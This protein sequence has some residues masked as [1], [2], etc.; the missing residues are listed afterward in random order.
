MS[1][2]DA[3]GVAI[4]SLQ[5]SCHWRNSH[6]WDLSMESKQLDNLV[7]TGSLK[8]EP[9]IQAEYDGLVVSG[10]KS[11]PTPATNSWLSKVGSIWHTT[12]R[13]LLHLRRFA[14]MVLRPRT[15]MGFPGDPTHPEPWA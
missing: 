12:E 5:G 15:S 3:F 7:R 14:C 4:H 10:R 9:V 11:L 8:H 1:L 2:E 6:F 13:F